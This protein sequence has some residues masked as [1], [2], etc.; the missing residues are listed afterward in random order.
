MVKN[1]EFRWPGVGNFPLLPAL[2]TPMDIMTL[3]V[4]MVDCTGAVMLFHHLL[5]LYGQCVVLVRGRDGVEM[6]AV[7]FGSEI[8]NP[9]LQFRWFFRE[10]NRHK[11]W[12]AEIND[13]LFMFMFGF[14]RIA[15]GSV[16][17]YCTWIHPLPD[18]HAKLGGLAIYLL[19]WVFWIMIV[20]Y[21]IRK[22]KKKF[23]A[24][25]EQESNVQS[26]QEADVSKQNGVLSNGTMTNVS[27]G[28][29]QHLKSE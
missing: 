18:M 1:K 19:G 28:V 15:L 29:N 10:S 9:F 16:L 11:T 21:A 7:L 3:Y 5:S 17:L 23:K 22:Y 24:W 27:N 12:L 8:S 6:M 26:S 4:F 13:H 2:P 14:W 20:D 25:K